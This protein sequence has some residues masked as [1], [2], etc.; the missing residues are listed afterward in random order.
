ML[1][2]LSLSVLLW[3]GHVISRWD[4]AFPA[5]TAGLR[6]GLWGYV[7]IRPDRVEQVTSYKLFTLY[8][9]VPVCANSDVQDIDNSLTQS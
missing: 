4:R 7:R 5:T 8:W 9:T 6:Y 2:L 1:S 3:F